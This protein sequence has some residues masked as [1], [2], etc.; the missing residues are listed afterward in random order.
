[1]RSTGVLFE[2]RGPKQNKN[3]SP[4]ELDGDSGVGQAP[5]SPFKPLAARSS[6]KL[7]K[8]AKHFF[9]RLAGALGRDEYSSRLASKIGTVLIIFSIFGFLLTYG[10]ILKVEVGYRLS[11]L[12]QKDEA[13]KGSFA[14][15]LNKTFLGETEGVPDPAFSLIIPKIH[16]KGKIVPEVDAGNEAEYFAALKT[17]VAHA[18]GTVFP[19]SSGNVYLFAHSTDSPINILRYNAI[20]YLLKELE[21]GD[22]IQ[23]YYQ[24]VKHRYFVAEKKIVEPTD[25]S[26]LL[27]QNPEGR[28]QLILQTCW[29][30]GTTLKRLLI[31]A[32]KPQ[33]Q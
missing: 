1:M 27:P 26:Y 15:I 30:P 22:E 5:E 24:G 28:E 29:P 19:G 16:A 11:R 4:E 25:V 3:A 20:F 18:K 10:P 7:R 17:G 14:D 23:V 21:V 32:K 33:S 8:Q 2:N 9:P 13:Q 12:F 31:F 6:H